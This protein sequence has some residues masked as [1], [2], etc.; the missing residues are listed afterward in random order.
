MKALT[1]FFV[2]KI[3]FRAVYTVT[4]NLGYKSA[5]RDARSTRTE[6]HH[7]VTRIY[8][9]RL[10]AERTAVAEVNSQSC[11]HLVA[12]VPCHLHA[13]KRIVVPRIN[14]WQ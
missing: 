11:R 14:S 9:D 8:V 2:F 13:V 7:D 4:K 10:L 6:R 12:V 5:L 1:Q 3:K